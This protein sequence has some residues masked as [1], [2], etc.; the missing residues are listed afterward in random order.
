MGYIKNSWSSV[1]L[2]CGN[3]S[4]EQKVEMVIQQGPHSLFY[5]C[6]H[7]YEQNREEGERPCFNRLNLVDFER[8]L[9]HLADVQMDDETIVSLDHYKWKKNGVE[10]QVISHKDGKI[11][12]RVLNR[13]ALR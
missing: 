9:S 12:L 6:P 2:I 1:K 8:A 5:A 7:Y 13:K 10:Y 3:H 4:D 11:V